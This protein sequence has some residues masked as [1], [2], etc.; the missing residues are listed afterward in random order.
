MPA[1]LTNEGTPALIKELDN[2]LLVVGANQTTSAEVEETIRLCGYIPVG[3]IFLNKLKYAAPDW[4]LSLASPG[5]G[6]V[7]P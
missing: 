3:G 2:I 5:M 7:A 1:V 4:L 6:R